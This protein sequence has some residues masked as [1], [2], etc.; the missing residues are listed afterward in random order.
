[1]HDH[2]QVVDFRN[3]DVEFK[4]RVQPFSVKAALTWLFWHVMFAV[5]ALYCLQGQIIV[6][7]NVEDCFDVDRR[8]FP[9][10]VAASEGLAR[11]FE[12]AAEFM[13]RCRYLLR[14]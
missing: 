11:R 8:N 13:T 14:Q 6:D 10:K 4:I 7:G 12:H 5:C 2:A 9:V 3:K 1:M